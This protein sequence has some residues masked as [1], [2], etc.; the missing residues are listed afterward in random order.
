MPHQLESAFQEFHRQVRDAGLEA[1]DVSDSSGREFRRV[2]TL[3]HDGAALRLVWQ[4]PSGTLRLEGSHGPPA[5]GI[6]GWLDLYEAVL[7]DGALRSDQTDFDLRS[8]IAY[9]IELMQPTRA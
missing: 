9:G 6:A 8:A 3:T 1:A 5:G 4:M 2:A 7:V